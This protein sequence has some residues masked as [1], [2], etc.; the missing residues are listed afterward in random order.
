[1]DVMEEGAEG[2]LQLGEVI[3]IHRRLQLDDR[4]V[5][6]VERVAAGDKDL[7]VERRPQSSLLQREVGGDLRM[8]V[9][10]PVRHWRWRGVRVFLVNSVLAV[11]GGGEK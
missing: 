2:S 5:F 3:L 1:M 4:Q 9:N 6:T 7:V 11:G 10:R 8:R